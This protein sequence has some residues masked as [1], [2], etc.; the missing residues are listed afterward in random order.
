M[1]NQRPIPY[2]RFEELLKKRDELKAHAWMLHEQQI[3]ALELVESAFD[4]IRG[5]MERNENLMQ[6]HE[7]RTGTE[8]WIR[9][10]IDRNIF[11]GAPSAAS[12]RIP[13]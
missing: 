13:R 3:E 6:A 1:N 9:G 5:L 8:S 11:R 10:L 2:S 4:L 7:R 12:R